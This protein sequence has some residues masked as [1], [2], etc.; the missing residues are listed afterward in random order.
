MKEQEALNLYKELRAVISKLLDNKEANYLS[1]LI[2]YDVSFITDG[3][4][5]DYIRRQKTDGSTS[6]I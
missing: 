2:Y 1:K 5:T 3:D 6:S 4:L